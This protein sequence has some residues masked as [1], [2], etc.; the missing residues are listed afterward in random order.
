MKISFME[1]KEINKRETA[2]LSSRMERSASLLGLC[3]DS[4]PVI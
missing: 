4:S 3:I 2:M 1:N